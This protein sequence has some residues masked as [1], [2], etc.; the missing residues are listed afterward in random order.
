M[1]NIVCKNIIVLLLAKIKKLMIKRRIINNIN[2]N[3]LLWNA[4]AA[5]AGS[6]TEKKVYIK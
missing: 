2:Y 3:H 4:V 6:M 1:L 5:I